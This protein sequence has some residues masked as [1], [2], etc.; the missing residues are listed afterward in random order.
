MYI[1]GAGIL[2]YVD[3]FICSCEVVYMC[4]CWS[5]WCYADLRVRLILFWGEVAL[6]RCS[7]AHLLGSAFFG[8][9]AGISFCFVKCVCVCLIFVVRSF[10]ICV[11]ASDV[12]LVRSAYLGLGYVIFV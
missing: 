2:I 5:Y 11:L 10:Y 6:Q 1:L 8:G 9:C 4:E 7:Y 12:F 3:L